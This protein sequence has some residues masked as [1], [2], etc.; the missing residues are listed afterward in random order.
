MCT[1][2]DARCFERSIRAFFGF[3]HQAIKLLI[4]FAFDWLNVLSFSCICVCFRF[5][6][7]LNELLLSSQELIRLHSLTTFPRNNILFLW[8]NF[9]TMLFSTQLRPSPP[10]KKSQPQQSAN[11]QAACRQ[12]R[13]NGVI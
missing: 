10:P 13:R 8:Q 11:P 1:F 3:E 12:P 5:D 2:W 7:L 9:I 4:D 6:L